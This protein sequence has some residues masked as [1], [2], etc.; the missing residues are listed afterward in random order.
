MSDVTAMTSGLMETGERRGLIRVWRMPDLPQLELRRGFAVHSPVPRHWHEEYQFCFVQSGASELK[1]RG[2]SLLTPPASLFMVSPGEV[3]SNRVFDRA[4]C[5][6]R[7]LFVGAE[8]MQR[9]AT[10]VQGAR[11]GLPFF[12]TAVV[13]DREVIVQYLELHIALE[14]P[15]SRLERQTL[16]V[17]FLVALIQRFAETRPRAR[18][19]GVERQAVRRALD[20]LV[21]YY[22]EN[23][24]LENLAR[25]ANLSPFHFNRVFSEE[26]GMPPH[27]FQTQLRIARA[28][29]LL[30]QGW[31]IPQVACQTG[32]FDQSHLNRHFKRVVGVSPGQFQL[33]SKNVQDSLATAS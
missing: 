13:F 7:D 15:A 29:A 33:S 28:K 14:R 4:G 11:T 2:S 19:G 22:A 23:V 27:A 5:S 6:Y 3:H 31:L 24:S 17:N 10:E 12:P 26:F 20:Y 21:E 32:F 30:R 1:F 18:T 9:V 25:I 8:L 16:V